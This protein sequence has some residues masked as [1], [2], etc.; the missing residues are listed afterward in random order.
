MRALVAENPRDGVLG[1]TLP[2]MGPTGQ[3]AGSES[4][5][6]RGSSVVERRV[7]PGGRWFKSTSRDW[8]GVMRD[9]G[10]FRVWFFVPRISGWSSIPKV[11]D[12]GSASESAARLRAAEFEA[13]ILPVEVDYPPGQLQPKRRRNGNGS[14]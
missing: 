13:I 6:S 9:D 14:Q 4:A 10:G 2:L 1:G 11:M 5:E 3:S 7:V 8:I 12:F